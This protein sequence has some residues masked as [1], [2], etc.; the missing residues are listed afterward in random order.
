M[1]CFKHDDSVSF[2]TYGDIKFFDSKIQWLNDRIIMYFL[3]WISL[4]S[5]KIDALDLRAFKD[6]KLQDAK[7]KTILDTITKLNL[8]IVPF[9]TGLHF[10]LF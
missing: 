8:I 3:R 6:Y 7:S 2:L 1:N 5:S 9:Y 4:Q 10:Y